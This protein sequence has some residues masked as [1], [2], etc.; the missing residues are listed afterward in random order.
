MNLGT[1]LYLLWLEFGLLQHDFEETLKVP[2]VWLS[3]CLNNMKRR[4]KGCLL[5]IFRLLCPNLG[6]SPFWDTAY[7]VVAEM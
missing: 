5:D 3:Y 1:S 7:I 4:Q 6:T 2:L